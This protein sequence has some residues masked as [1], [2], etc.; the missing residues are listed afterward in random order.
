MLTHSGR[1]THI[2]V[3]KL[4]IIGSDNGLSP[5]RCQA[6][7]STNAAILIIVSLG[8][9]FSE[10]LNEIKASLLKE[11]CLKMSAAKC[12][13]FRVDLNVFTRESHEYVYGMRECKGT[14]SK[15]HLRGEIK[16]NKNMVL[17]T[18]LVEFNFLWQNMR[19]RICFSSIHRQNTRPLSVK[20]WEG[21]CL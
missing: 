21:V 1:V 15:M 5:R 13:P 7:N 16:G 20:F 14:W 10:I 8:T 4:T 2:C 6:I 17:Y 12:C 11:I 3:A 19:I 9:N 18:S